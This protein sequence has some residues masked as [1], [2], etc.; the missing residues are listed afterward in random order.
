M[1]DPNSSDPPVS[2]VYISSAI[3]NATPS[4]IEMIYN[5]ALANIVP[6]ASAFSCSGQFCCQ[7]RT[8]LFLVFRNQSV[9][10]PLLTGPVI[11]GNV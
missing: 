9:A 3:E 7:K 1:A 8:I 11:S 6:A 2:P 5:I 10:D 4:V